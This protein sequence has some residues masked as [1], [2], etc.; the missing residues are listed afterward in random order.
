MQQTGFAAFAT[1]GVDQPAKAGI[2][3][4]SETT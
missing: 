4:K 3:R 1:R 2:I